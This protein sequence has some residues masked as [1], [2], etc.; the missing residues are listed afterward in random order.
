MEIIRMKKAFLV[1]LFFLALCSITYLLAQP[2][3]T[4]DTIPGGNC[5]GSDSCGGDPLMIIG[6]RLRCPNNWMVVCPYKP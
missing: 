3:I 1:I 5:L 6:C 4:C 2:W